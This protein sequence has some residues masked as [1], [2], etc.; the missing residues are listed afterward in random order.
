MLPNCYFPTMQKIINGVIKMFKESDPEMQVSEIDAV[1]LRCI[2][3]R[4]DFKNATIQNFINELKDVLED[5]AQRKNIHNHVDEN[6]YFGI[7]VKVEK[8]E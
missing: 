6:G 5:I 2:L 8:E 4:H 7:L 1:Y 3:A